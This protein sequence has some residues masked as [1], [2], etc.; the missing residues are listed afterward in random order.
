M[1]TGTLFLIAIVSIFLI[2]NIILMLTPDSKLRALLL[3]A[4]SVIFIFLIL[5]AINIIHIPLPAMIRW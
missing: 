1:Q 5:D 2:Y 4:L 3:A